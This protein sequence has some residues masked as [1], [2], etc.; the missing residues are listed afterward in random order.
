MSRPPVHKAFSA[1]VIGYPRIGPRRELKK[2]LEAYWAGSTTRQDLE[3]AARRIRSASAASLHSAGL[4]S[5][6]VNTF[7]YYDQ[8]LDTA[9]LLGAVPTRFAD[10]DDDLD[11]YFAMARGLTDGPPLEMTKWFDTNYHYLVP[12]IAPDSVFSLHPEKVLDDFREAMDAGV[13]ARPVILGPISFLELAKPAGIPDSA[14]KGGQR[15]DLLARLAELLPLYGELLERLAQAGAHWVQLDEPALTSDLDDAVREA[16]HGAYRALTAP[17]A[18]PSILVAGYFGDCADLLRVLSD[19]DVEGV[20]I[21]LVAGATPP[22]DAT[23]VD[24]LVVAGIVDGRNVWRTDPDA[25]LRRLRALSEVTSSV[26]VST[27]C[28][29]QHV[30]YTLTAEQH[31]D[32]QLRSWLAFADEKVAEVVAL[33]RTLTSPG[34]TEDPAIG[35]ARAAAADRRGS[36]RT[37]QQQVRARVAELDDDA[38]H[39]GD[40]ALRAEQQASRLGLPPL[41][42]TTIGSFPQ[43]AEIRRARGDLRAGRIDDAGYLALM[44]AEVASVI[45]MQEDLG[46]DVLVHGEPERNDM[47]QY[48]AEQLEG[49]AVTDN[50]WVQS[51]G[52]RCVRPPILF[53]DVSRPRP[54]TVEWAAYA[55][56]LT[57]RPVKGMLT[58]PVTMLAWSFVRDDQPLPDTAYQVALAVRDEAVDLQAAGIA[59]IQVDEPALRELLPLSRSAWPQYLD[60]AVRAFRL[61]TSGVKDATSVH[62]HLCYS[63]FGDVIDAI[64][65]LQADVTSVEAARSGME[66]LNDLEA[67]GYARGVGPGVYDIHSPRVPTQQEMTELL[68]RAV[69]AVGSD[70]LWVNPD[71]GLKTRSIAEVTAAL[72]NMVAAARDIR[73]RL[74]SAR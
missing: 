68:E 9:V 43:T 69:A 40:A 2:A 22:S 51:Y 67:A 64:A 35:L 53:G 13:P 73:S 48:F 23:P 39:R 49:F 1:T 65:A 62:T 38:V 24:K 12:E 19:T 20:A 25:A 41:P 58:G 3:R 72:R 52:S 6:P 8:V 31:I 56:G 37:R 16:A 5:V 54:M 44:H 45:G 32:P 60:W 15:H 7:S 70:R 10:I 63:E 66:I 30:P 26:A 50:G 55:Q 11:R 18:R 33:S 21:D 47:V 46:L 14:S 4:D 28:S 27:S 74:V 71:C 17:T 42:T 34:G 59:I 57:V 61:A 29:L 36:A